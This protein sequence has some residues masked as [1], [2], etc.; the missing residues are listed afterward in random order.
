MRW[1]H[2][3]RV[4]ALMIYIESFWN[5]TL[6]DRMRSSVCVTLGGFLVGKE[7]VTPRLLGSVPYPAGVCLCDLGQ[8]ILLE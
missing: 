2:T 6:E 4:I 3:R 5:R 7:P 1:A 8:K